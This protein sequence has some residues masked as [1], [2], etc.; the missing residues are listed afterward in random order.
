[1]NT[2]IYQQDGEPPHC[3]DRPLEFLGRYFPVD[4]LIWHRTDF[5]W[6]PYSP[7]LKPM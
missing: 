5:P 1:M 3:S 6:P 4:R 2:A 7:D